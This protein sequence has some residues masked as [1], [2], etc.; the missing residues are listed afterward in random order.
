MWKSM[1]CARYV[2]GQSSAEAAREAWRIYTTF[3]ASSMDIVRTL[4]S[5]DWFNFFRLMSKEAGSLGDNYLGCPQQIWDDMLQAGLE[6]QPRFMEELAVNSGVESLREA[7][8]VLEMVWWGS[9]PSM[10]TDRLFGIL[11]KLVG[12]KGDADAVR[13]LVRQA[14]DMRKAGPK[15]YENAIK[16]LCRC[17]AVEDAL[18]LCSRMEATGQ[19][20]VNDYLL[21]A[22]IQ[23]CQQG[24]LFKWAERLYLWG[25][26]KGRAQHHSDSAFVRAKCLEGDIEGAFQ[27][28][29]NLTS[30]VGKNAGRKA[31]HHQTRMWN[32]LLWCCVQK[33]KF[34]LVTSYVAT[35]RR[36][37]VPLNASSFD[38]LIHAAGHMGDVESAANL[39]QSMQTIRPVV[40]P[41]VETYN[42]LIN[43]MMK[44]GLDDEALDVFE[45]MEHDKARP[46]RITYNTV[47]DGLLR[48]RKYESALEVFQKMT[49]EGLQ[50][51]AITCST[52][53]RALVGLGRL[54]D[55]RAF[56]DE[57]LHRM[58]SPEDSL[59]CITVM[60]DA[61]LKS[62]DHVQAVMLMEAVKKRGI[63]PDNVLYTCLLHSSSKAG[64]TSAVA[65]LWHRASVDGI[66]PDVGMYNALMSGDVSRNRL[67]EAISLLQ[68]MA[69]A[70]VI[71]NARTYT[72][73]MWALNRQGRME[74]CEELVAAMT[75]QN[76]NIGIFHHVCIITGWLKRGDGRRA[77]DYWKRFAFAAQEAEVMHRHPDVGVEA[78]IWVE[79]VKQELTSVT[80]MKKSS[81]ALPSHDKGVSRRHAFYLLN[82]SLRQGLLRHGLNDEAAAVATHM[83]R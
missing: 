60:V 42:I 25:K 63:T 5:D 21:A 82:E 51:N 67:G 68:A 1:L 46:D 41:T 47:I 24:K 39:F 32:H 80:D 18:A 72:I 19:G 13:E 31:Q 38:A 11:I 28:C 16:A 55:A 76:I 45:K 79:T 36:H 23:A 64:D 54:Q 56:L 35:M 33:Q 12:A 50:P 61:Y 71:P 43:T 78:K 73:L 30:T 49:T 10:V 53:L 40:H 20:L 15:C 69:S 6:M 77:F 74:E 66:E 8:Q 17:G 59:R 3:I 2:E 70:G 29:K 27:L 62:N 81:E 57:M 7:K 75:K 65:R 34:N 52:V 44:A 48:K 4:T 22:M 58:W 26:R 9:A 14:R 83:M 37:R